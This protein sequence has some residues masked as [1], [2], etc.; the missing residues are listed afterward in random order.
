MIQLRREMEEAVDREDY[1]RASE[2]RDE[3]LNLESYLGITG[4]T[5]F[6]ENGEVQRNLYLLRIKGRRFVEVD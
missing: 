4:T 1:E 5:G 6:D 3:L 2:I